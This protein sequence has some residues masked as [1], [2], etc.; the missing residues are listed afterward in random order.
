[1][2]FKRRGYQRVDTYKGPTDIPLFVNISGTPYTVNFEHVTSHK[3]FRR[4]EYKEQLSGAIARIIKCGGRHSRWEHVFGAYFNGQQEVKQGDLRFK[5]PFDEFVFHSLNLLH[6]IGQGPKSHIS[7]IALHGYGLENHKKRAIRIIRERMGPPLAA[8]VGNAFGPVNFAEQVAAEMEREGPIYNLVAAK[9]GGTDKLDYLV[10]DRKECKLG[11]DI[12]IE[13]LISGIVFDGEQHGIRFE[14]RDKVQ[15]LIEILVDNNRNLYLDGDVETYEGFQIR[16]MCYVIDGAEFRRE[17]WH[18]NPE[19]L[20]GFTDP[21][22]DHEI[23]HNGEGRHI[24]EALDDKPIEWW[25]PV[26]YIKLGPYGR[27]AREEMPGAH[28]DEVTETDLEGLKEATTLPR[29]VALEK[30]L[31]K[32]LDLTPSQIVFTT[33][34]QIDRLM[35]RSPLLA[36]PRGDGYDFRPMSELQPNFLTGVND[37]LKEHWS[38]RLIA[39]QDAWE[40]VRSHVEDKGGLKALLQAA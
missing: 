1:M 21:E 22:L 19:D 23:H 27:V 39:S 29:L 15:Q 20:Y 25:R 9:I 37:R 34:P 31:M 36:Y 10:R 30:S 16:S 5:T 7:E 2:V 24:A 18:V 17:G 3:D 13:T 35:L 12:E 28:V 6:D 8:A 4:L 40:K 14:L 38:V 32:T 33:S 26:G 11:G